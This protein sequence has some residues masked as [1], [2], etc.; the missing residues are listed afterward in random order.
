VLL[1][2]LA[3]SRTLG[4]AFYLANPQDDSVWVCAGDPLLRVANWF[5]VPEPPPDERPAAGLEE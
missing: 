2:A 4:E 1:A 5:D 3:E